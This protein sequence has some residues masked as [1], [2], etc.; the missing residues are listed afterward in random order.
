MLKTKNWGVGAYLVLASDIC[1]VLSL[2][3]CFWLGIGVSAASSCLILG[4]IASF[5]ALYTGRDI[6]AYPGYL[7]YIAA[8]GFAI[9]AELYTIST[10]IMAIDASGFPANLLYT[11]VMLLTTVIV[12]F[13][14]TVASQRKA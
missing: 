6:F 5:L 11:G 7:L 4:I 8:F 14:S 10:V 13:A 9:Y 1:A 3:G 12:S 2:I